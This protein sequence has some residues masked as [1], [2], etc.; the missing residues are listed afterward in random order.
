MNCTG[1]ESARA[2][3]GT[4]GGGLDA[5]DRSNFGSRPRNTAE[6]REQTCPA[7][8]PPAA[9]DAIGAKPD[10]D[11]WKIPERNA[12]GEIIGWS[13]RFADGHKGYVAGGKRGLTMKYPLAPYAG[14]SA[15]DPVFVVEGA[16]DTAA[17]VS[18]SL[19]TVG[20]PSN[21]GGGE[22][23][24]ALLADRHVC[25]VG[26]NDWKPGRKS[27]TV[28]WP[29]RDG[30]Q[31]IARKLIGA[32]PSV[33]IIFPPDGV[34]DLRAWVAE[35]VTREDI[36]PRVAAA[37][38]VRET[39]RLRDTGADCATLAK[40]GPTL[41]LTNL[42]GVEPKPVE[43]VW[44]GRIP[45]GMLTVI[46]GDPGGGKSTFSAYVAAMVTTGLPWIDDLCALHRDPGR[47]LFLTA[48]DDT[49]R[50]LVPRLLK[51]G[52]DMA[53]VESI[54]GV[55][56]QPDGPAAT[57]ELDRDLD[58][59]RVA[60]DSHPD[61]RLI[62]ID[63]ITAYYGRAARDSNNTAVMRGML[64]PLKAF[65]EA[66][67]IAVLAITHLNKSGGGTSATRR[68]TGSLALPAAARAVYLLDRAPE[69]EDRR[70]LLIDKMNV[71]PEPKGLAFRLTDEKPPRIEWEPEPL[72]MKARDLLGESGDHGGPRP[73]V[74]EAVEFLRHRLG[75]HSVPGRTVA[76]D[77]HRAGI[78]SRS[79]NDACGRLRVIKGPDDF[80]GPWVWRLPE[81]P[82]VGQSRTVSQSHADRPEGEA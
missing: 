23:L 44:E 24:V 75:G 62:V 37:E 55:Q 63:P 12:E 31:G 59:L 58:L 74:E 47:V 2:L 3:A 48:E 69:Q 80:G 76:D 9:W 5:E 64:S 77:A 71:G 66:T 56:L 60:V 22:L 53:L 1:Q 18:L 20:R 17:G 81:S 15:S 7:H 36:L 61:T 82:S 72:A 27:G 52:A 73:A 35:G 19:D 28:A 78:S 70:L 41:V 26:E 54:D 49:A 46:A 8:V 68:I 4:A 43:W 50:V 30:A 13:R 42:A 40:P 65:C 10:G 6:R 57:M 29:G 67:G 25:I 21:T 16:T 38:P 39:E 45:A 33:R 32:C 34:K 51:A 14:S 11:G 79:L